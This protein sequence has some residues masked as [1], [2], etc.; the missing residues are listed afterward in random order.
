MKTTK[1][2]DFKKLGNDGFEEIRNEIMKAL[3]PIA[4]NLGV[5]FSI[6]KIGYSDTYCKVPLTISIVGESGEVQTPEAEAF[7]Q[8]AHLYDLKPENLFAKFKMG[9]VEYEIIGLNTRSGKYP[10][11]CRRV[12]DGQAVKVAADAVKNALPK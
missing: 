6:G 10:I 8:V 1:I 11:K 9:G 5:A 3:Q 2:R 12:K 7:K 4:D